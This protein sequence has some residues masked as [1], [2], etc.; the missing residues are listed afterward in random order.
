MGNKYY[1]VKEGRNIGVYET[2]AECES[3]VKGYSGASYKKFPTYEEAI[4]FINSNEKAY[5]EKEILKLK[6]NEMVAYVDGSFD[7]D[8]KYYSYGAVIF[9]AEG[10]EIYSQKENDE[11]MVD[12]RNVAGEIRGAMYAMEQALRKGKDVLY[13]HYDYV[14]IEKW[15]TGE[16]KTNKDGTRKYKEYYD[17]IKDKLKVEF[18]KVKAHSGDKYNEEADKLAKEVL[19]IEV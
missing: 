1:A 13:L 5:K 2:W 9:T 18:E 17:S 3:Q 14:G 12:M 6:G 16:W 19:D 4:S 10:K 8:S 11:T 7:K 15:A